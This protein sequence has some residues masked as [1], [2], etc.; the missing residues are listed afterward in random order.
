MK[1]IFLFIIIIINREVF[2]RIA[3][4]HLNQTLDNSALQIQ[5]KDASSYEVVFSAQMSDKILKIRLFL[6][7]DLVDQANEDALL[8]TI[9]QVAQASCQIASENSRAEVLTIDCKD[10]TAS[11]DAENWDGENQRLSIRELPELKGRISGFNAETVIDS[12]HRN[13]ISTLFHRTI[14]DPSKQKDIEKF[15]ALLS[16]EQSD[17]TTH[18]LQILIH[19]FQNI[20]NSN[21]RAKILSDLSH[22]R[23]TSVTDLIR[24]AL[25]VEANRFLDDIVKNFPHRFNLTDLIANK[26]V[27][28]KTI[29]IETI[30]ALFNSNSIRSV[31]ADSLEQAI[32]NRRKDIAETILKSGKLQPGDHDTGASILVTAINRKDIHLVTLL[33]KLD[34]ININHDFKGDSPITRAIAR[35]QVK[36]VKLLLNDPRTDPNYTPQNGSETPI[37]TSYRY[38]NPELFTPFLTHPKINPDPLFKMLE[39]YPH[40]L[41]LETFDVLQQHSP[42]KVENFLN[43]HPSL[44]AIRLIL[45]DKKQ[46]KEFILNELRNNP[47]FSLSDLIKS[48]GETVTFLKN[49]MRNEILAWIAESPHFDAIP[50][51]DQMRIISC[52][53]P[54]HLSD[55]G[56]L[57]HKGIEL[58]IQY[59]KEKKSLPE[60]D[61]VTVCQDR[62]RFQEA[63]SKLAGD[64]NLPDGYTHS[65]VVTKFNENPYGL[66]AHVTP[67]LVRKNGNKWDILITDSTTDRE[68]VNSPKSSCQPIQEII[69]NLEQTGKFPVRHLHM[70]TF[71]RQSDSVSCP[72]FT[73]RDIVFFHRNGDTFLNQLHTQADEKKIHLFTHLSPELMKMTQ[74][75]RDLDPYLRS[76]KDHKMTRRKTQTEET[77]IENLNRHVKETP[78][79]RR[80]MMATERAEKYQKL[81]IE[82]LRETLQRA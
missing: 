52:F 29:N 56:I 70:N 7:A 30:N 66:P 59:L 27:S 39:E 48:E 53:F 67:V 12:N 23:A 63:L 28:S 79:G 31:S 37:E 35:E 82:R 47:N 14:H 18:E 54:E 41:D 26:A 57:G 24:C 19:S 40:L 22:Y 76:E 21:E 16:S 51:Q 32:E 69:H 61:F 36:I 9:R 5:K 72:I 17:Y 11:V 71:W 49:A 20:E 81:M 6:A 64:Q 60:E 65:F 1:F 33:L 38:D 74:S 68:N 15:I 44:K 2:M 73:L 42:E 8:Q 4:N 75:L 55:N 13:E 58:M 62:N 34:W 3:W 80:N 25:D 46:A 10:H 50:H 77:F 43:I 78:S 45:T